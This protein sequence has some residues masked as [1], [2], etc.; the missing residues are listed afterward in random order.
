[1]EDTHHGADLLALLRQHGVV[2]K[3]PQAIKVRLADGIIRMLMTLRTAKREPEAHG[4]DGGGHVVEEDVAA[5]DL[6]VH[7]R[8][9][10]PGQQEARGGLRAH[11][12]SRNLLLHKLIERLVCIQRL[13]H[14]VPILPSPAPLFIILKPIRLREPSEIQPPLRPMLAIAGRFQKTADER[15]I[16]FVGPIGQV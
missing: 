14:P 2:E 1:M 9:V 4:A 5:F 10:R 7:V 11:Q 16:L 3:G 8:H 15:F 12:I 6:V 13:D